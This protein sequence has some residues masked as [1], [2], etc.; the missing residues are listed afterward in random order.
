ML[1]EITADGGNRGRERKQLVRRV[2][3]GLK[4]SNYS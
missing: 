1:R 3:G 2:E 4:V